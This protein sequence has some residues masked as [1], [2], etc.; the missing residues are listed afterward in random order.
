V[1]RTVDQFPDGA[2]EEDGQS[3]QEEKTKGGKF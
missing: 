2:E 1:N 3:W